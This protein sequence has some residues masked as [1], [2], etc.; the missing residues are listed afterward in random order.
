[1]APT[2]F[3]K[4]RDPEL[5]LAARRDQSS[6]DSAERVSGQN[7]RHIRIVFGREM[8]NVLRWQ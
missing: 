1:V 2:E 4:V 7:E 3:R 6:R 5:V 8:S